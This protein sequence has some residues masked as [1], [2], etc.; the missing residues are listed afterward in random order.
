V[1]EVADGQ[2]SEPGD[3][4]AEGA[5]ELRAWALA[6]VETFPPWSDDQWRDINVGLGYRLKGEKEID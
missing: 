5:E 1:A 6:L 4:G 3:S 2:G